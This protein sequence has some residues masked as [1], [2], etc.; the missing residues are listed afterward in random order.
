MIKKT[1]FSIFLFF[2]IL[3]YIVADP[4]KGQWK[5]FKY[6]DGLSSNYIF[7]VEKDENNRIWIGTQNG[8][9][10]IDGSII[11]K[12]GSSDG[13]PAADI[14]KIASIN[15]TIYAATSNKGIYEFNNDSFKKSTIVQ[16]NELK[17]MAKVGDQIFVSTNLENILY[18]GRNVSFM[19]KGFPNAW[20]SD[21]FTK[22][23]KTWYA[24]ENKIIQKQKN[25]FVSN[26]IKFPSTKIKI[27]AFIIVGETEYFGTNQGLWFREGNSALKRLKNI[28]VLSLDHLESGDILIGSKKGLYYLR[29]G[30]L[31]QYKPTGDDHAFLNNTPIL[32]IEVISP[33]EIW[34]S[35]FGMGLYLHDP[36]TFINFNSS[37]GLDTGDMVYDL[38]TQNG[39]VYIATGNGLFIYKN[40]LITDHYTT[41][42]GLLSNKILDIEIDSKGALW[43]ATAK[44]LSHF[45]GSKFKNYSRKDGLPSSL[46]TAVHIDQNDDSRI[47]MGSRSSGL[48]RFDAKGFYTFS[49][50]D[51]LPS[52]NIQDIKQ[53]ENGDLVLAC[54]NKGVAKYDGKK[55]KLFDVGLDDK[56]V[57]SIAFGPENQIWAGTESAGIGVLEDNRFRMIRDT[58]GL[59]HNE[60]FSLYNDGSRMWAGTFGG[61]VSCFYEGTWFTMNEL[62]GLNSNSIGAIIS[63]NP[64]QVMIGGKKGISIFTIDDTPF[65]LNINK[66][67]TPKVDL[68]IKEVIDTPVSGIIKDRF[69]IH[70]NPMIYKTS[71][72]KIKYRTRIGKVGKEEKNKWSPLQS[73]PQIS[74]IAEN[75]G[76]YKFEIQAIDNRVS[77]SDIVTIPFKF[78]RIWYLDPKTALPFWGSIFL[79]IGFS[80]ITYIKYRNKSKEA[81]ELRDADIARQQAEMEEAREFQQAMLPKEMPSTDKY[82]MIGFQQTATEVGGDFFDFIQKED[83]NWIAICGDATGHG[84]TSGNVV[85]I[86]KTAMS[87]LVDKKPV[88]TLDSLNKTLLKMNIGLNR[89]CLNI[90]NIGNDSI[91]FSSAGMPPA[92]HYSAETKTLEEILVGA[93]P[94]G[95]FPGSIHTMH[96]VPFKDKGDLF[97]MMSDGLPE[98][99]N[100]N[101]EMVGYE[102][103]EE[104]IKSLAT[105]SVE[106]IKDG[107]VHLC[108]Q[109]LNDR[110]ELKDDMTFVIIKRK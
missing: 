52:N 15:N 109:W 13:L 62:D 101:D 67:E 39:K 110:A 21:V 10:L 78:S 64:N 27:Q 107:L 30:E 9:T 42:D 28:N 43:I 92:Y 54:Y 47:W 89:M 87:S 17:T 105:K 74:F 46:V 22:D 85:S 77:F 37:N 6:T 97:I 5:Q 104:E 99:E 69:Y 84:L 91:Q 98:A 90:A 66:I 50:Q 106:E 45:N 26:S 16:G 72:T 60:L 83:G 58:D 108:D 65:A 19:G 44:G 2:Q 71:N 80:S 1:T 48:T 7:D 100:M 86:T 14:V 56:R 40:S 36:G 49:V 3:N 103:T 41:T 20:V 12:Y 79:L 34:Y 11:K 93:L 70:A 94:L 32:S 75:V 33:D 96:E 82:E 35:T 88:P 61:G 81:Q 4:S 23:G 51:G 29:S 18:N 25:S 8:V 68:L 24:T 31:K 38:A 73:S 76:S 59:G 55:F 53:A 95:S 63:L 57:I 102:R